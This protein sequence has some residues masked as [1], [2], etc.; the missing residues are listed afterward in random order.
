MATG[1]DNRKMDEI[2]DKI[3]SRVTEKLKEMGVLENL[4]NSINTTLASTASTTSTASTVPAAPPVYTE[5]CGTPSSTCGDC[6]HCVTRKPEAIRNILNSGAVRIGSNTGVNGY[7]VDSKLAGMIDHTLLTPDASREQLVKLCD[8]AKKFNF[9][10]VCV[11]SANIPL[12]ARLLQGSKVKPIAVVGFP[13]GA[14]TSQSKA[15]EA[16]EAIRS[17]AE[18]ID[19]V[20]NIGALKSRE[21]QAVYED[22]KAV[23]EASRPHKVKVII[24]TA[25]LNDDEK[26][27][28]CTLAKTAG[29]AFVKTSTGFGGGG[30]TV[31]DIELMRR[32]VGSDMEVKAS[33]GIR[34]REDAQKMIKAGADRIG[35][36]ASVAIVTGQKTKK[37]NY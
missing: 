23:V 7:K 17:G 6:G 22:I 30:A 3:T 35:A 18:E 9:A 11:N 21:Y 28:A 33:G 29:A 19:M 20:I 32:V 5:V 2:V 10:T 34:T 37:G 27:I 15:F 25:Q 1:L 26:V 24:E 31:E 36:S 16:K 12:A 4:V 8:E 13:L 14:A